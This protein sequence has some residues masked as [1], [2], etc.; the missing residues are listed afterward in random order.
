LTDEP[1]EDGDW[2][3]WREKRLSLDQGM[4][5]LRFTEVDDGREVLGHLTYARRAARSGLR[6]VR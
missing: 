4:L 1:G 5:T 2:A 3:E 6:I